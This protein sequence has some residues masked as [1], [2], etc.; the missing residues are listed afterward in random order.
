MAMAM[1]A[2]CAGGFGAACWCRVDA[3]G[4]RHLNNA[5]QRGERGLGFGQMSEPIDSF[6]P[7]YRGLAARRPRYAEHAGS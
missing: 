6:P 3:A 5:P 4:A 7:Q 1:V 2:Q